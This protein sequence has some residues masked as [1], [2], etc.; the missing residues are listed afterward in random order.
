[1]TRPVAAVTAA[2]V[3]AAGV[4]AAS[5]VRWNGSIGHYGGAAIGVPTQVGKPFTVG[6]V[7]LEAHH[8]RVRIESIRL[9]GADPGLVL[10][11]TLTHGSSRGSIGAELR[12]PPSR[13]LPELRPAVGSVVPAHRELTLLVG[14]RATKVGSFRLRGVEVLYREEWH[15]LELRRSARAGFEIDV[16]AQRGPTGR[17]DPICDPPAARYL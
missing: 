14:L 13:R 1:V 7:D 9:L 11:G 8:G 15:G 16:C 17:G 5:Q 4:A 10:V 6:A 12:F 3:L 2:L